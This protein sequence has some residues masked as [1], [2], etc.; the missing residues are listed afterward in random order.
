MR[1]NNLNTLSGWVKDVMFALAFLTRLPVPLNKASGK[2]P[3]CEVAWAFPI[4][5]IIVGGL[6]GLALLLGFQLDQHPLVCGLFAIGATV[7]VTGALHEDGLADVADGFGGAHKVS[8]KLRIMHDSTVGSYGA[9][10]LVFSVALRAGTLAGMLTPSIAVLALI[11]AGAVSRGMVVAVMSQLDMARQDG[12]GASA[13]K[14]ANK[15]A[16]VALGLSATT[17]FLLLGAN[18]WIVLA[19]ALCAA[20]LMGWMAKRQIGGQTGDVLGAI[21]QVTEAA[22][23]LS[24]VAVI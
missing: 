3:L 17:A 22:V 24:V 2:R 9:L 6:A 11:T 23:L 10:A 7:L 18:G 12:L 19:V 5:G 14:P 15:G 16:L 21:Q 8:D 13:G 4:V 1:D 20:I